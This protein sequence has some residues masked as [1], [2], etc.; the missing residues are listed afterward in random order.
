MP[1]VST[2]GKS[3][4]SSSKQKANLPRKACKGCNIPFTPK[5]SRFN[6]H[7]PLCRKRYYD[8]TYF[9]KQDVKK[10]CKN[11]GISFPTS[12]PSKQDYCKPECRMAYQKAHPSPSHQYADKESKCIICS[13]GEADGVN[14]R[15]KEGKI[16]CEE[17][18]PIMEEAPSTTS[19]LTIKE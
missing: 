9:K 16:Y 3:I 18:Y 10:I 15:I 5:D 17:H 14:L 13:K 11:C 6:F 8:K 19:D 2:K 1:R 12:C 4:S 7:S